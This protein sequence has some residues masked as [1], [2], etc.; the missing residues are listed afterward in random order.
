MLMTHWSALIRAKRG[1]E[2]SEGFAPLSEWRVPNNVIFSTAGS[3]AL[4]IMLTGMG[5]TGADSLANVVLTA[6]YMLLTIQGFSGVLR[7]MKARGITRRV[8]NLFIALV[9][10]FGDTRFFQLLDIKSVLRLIGIYITLFGSGGAIRIIIK[11]RENHGGDEK[12]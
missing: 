12:R 1:D 6:L 11:K 8:R 7:R 9:L 5:I 3:L 2:R 4:S 10:L